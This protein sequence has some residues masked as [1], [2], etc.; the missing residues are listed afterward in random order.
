MNADKRRTLHQLRKSTTIKLCQIITECGI[1]VTYFFTVNLLQRNNNDLLIRY[2]ET[3]RESSVGCGE[4]SNRINRVILY[5][6]KY[7]QT[8]LSRQMRFV[9]H[10]GPELICFFF[11]PLRLFEK[12]F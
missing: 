12:R 2:I 11:A 10:Q 1:R 9:P 8:K 7:Q 3:L 5:S 6:P 4:L